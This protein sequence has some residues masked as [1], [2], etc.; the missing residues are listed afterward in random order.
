MKENIIGIDV[1]IEFG[2][3]EFAEGHISPHGVHIDKRQPSNERAR[4]YLEQIRSNLKDTL[5][6]RDGARKG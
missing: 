3:G 6:Y 2:G 4:P 5:R 1:K